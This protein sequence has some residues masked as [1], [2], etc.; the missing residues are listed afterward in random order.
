MLTREPYK[1][2]PRRF[3]IALV[4]ATLM[5]WCL[6]K[7]MFNT[8]ETDRYN[9]AEEYTKIF[10]TPLEL[11]RVTHYYY[12]HDCLSMAVEARSGKIVFKQQNTFRM[13]LPTAVIPEQWLEVSLAFGFQ[14]VAYKTEPW[15]KQIFFRPLFDP[16]DVSPDPLDPEKSWGM[17]ICVDAAQ[18]KAYVY[19]NQVSMLSRK[20]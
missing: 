9:L 16:N 10:E 15:V 6:V 3:I 17:W 1:I 11:V 12:G 7:I 14:T 2:T 20:L 4:I 13:L 18:S 5:S 8:R 19:C